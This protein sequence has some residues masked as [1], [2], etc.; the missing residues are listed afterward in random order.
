MAWLGPLARELSTKVARFDNCT[1]PRCWLYDSFASQPFEGNPAAVI[2]SKAALDA[3]L[4]QA[5]ASDLCAPTSVILWRQSESSFSASLHS[6]T[7]RIGMCGHA[8]LAG[9]A[10][11]FEEGIA[12]SPTSVRL[13]IAAGQTVEI[14]R[15]E[16]TAGSRNGVACA[17][18]LGPFHIDRFDAPLEPLLNALGV[19]QRDLHSSAPPTIADTG[20]RHALLCLRSSRTLENLHSSPSLF[21]YAQAH[22]FESIGVSA[23]ADGGDVDVHL[24]D[25]CPAI[26]NAE[27]SASGSTS[28]ATCAALTAAGVIEAR[29]LQ[30]LQGVGSSRMG[31]IEVQPLSRVD[32]ESHVC[33][34]IGRAIRVASIAFASIALAGGDHND[35]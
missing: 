29:K 13:D 18:T 21:E 14:E 4:M 3:G 5:L 17:L 32:A 9:A 23:L 20:L 10:A 30:V 26:G 34:V 2:V 12:P 19:A 1:V 33:R 16:E 35:D 24:R 22:G 6:P 8:L 7:R 15:C 28:A 31:R 11:L 27:E 25:F